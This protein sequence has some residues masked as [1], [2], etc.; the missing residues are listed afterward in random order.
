MTE[1]SRI[2]IITGK[3][4]QNANAEQLSG[5]LK[6]AFAR[7]IHVDI[8]VLQEE[9]QE[10]LLNAIQFS[11]LDGVIF[12]PYSFDSKEYSDNLEQFLSEHC[13]KPVVRIGIEKTSFTQIWY[14]ANKEIAEITR[15]LI[16]V[17]HCRQLLCLTEQEQ[18]PV[19][20]ERLSGFREALAEAGIPCR[21][22]ENIIYGDF[23]LFTVQKL[24][25]EFANGTRTLPEAI[26]CTDDLLAIALCDALRSYQISVPENVLVT[27][28]ENT[29]GTAMHSPSV[30]TYAPA[31]EQLGRRALCRLY[32]LITGKKISPLKREKGSF[33]RR[34]SCGCPEKFSPEMYSF[35]PEQNMMEHSLFTE[36]LSC[37]SLEKFS[38]MMYQLNYLFLQP[39]HYPDE[40]Y[41]LCLH[42]NW[43]Q[44][45]FSHTNHMLRLYEHGGYALFPAE[46][47]L[48]PDF[49][50][51]EQP[52]A[53]FFCPVQFQ[54]NYFGYALLQYTGI[55]EK[56]H[57][58]YL[59][60]CQEISHALEFLR[61]RNE[62]ES[63]AYHDYLSGVR[64]TLTG[65]YHLNQLPEMWQEYLARVNFRKQKAFWLALNISGIDQLE[66]TQGSL[67][68]DKLLV[69]FA[70]LLQNVCSE[71]ENCFRAGDHTFLIL[72]SEPEAAP[73]HTIMVQFIRERFETYQYHR[74]QMLLPVQAAVL[75][76]EEIQ[77]L[78]EDTLITAAS[79]LVARSKANQILYADR[80]HDK[81]LKKLRQQIYQMPEK[82]WSVKLCSQQ[83]NISISYF[84]KIYFKTFG[85]TCAYDIRRSKME[86]G[87]YLLLHTSDT[88]QEI[89][90]KCGY[91]YSHFMRTFRKFY[92]MT[93]TEYRRGK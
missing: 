9:K 7:N 54:E 18:D 91:E 76:D 60:F 15:H 12:L 42:E 93:P 59:P 45:K 38:I 24:A 23:Y 62:L 32:K 92:Q 8:F 47:M 83:L 51:S 13:T 25:Q 29:F 72:G 28:Y 31:W 10:H 34:H 53:T 79:S 22:Q 87:K 75:T 71:Q 40:R 14:S 52:T 46:Q 48:P 64:D 39:D 80:L 78:T 70:E 89:C 58:Y 41:C 84:C 49:Q 65:L 90:R 61:I 33:I 19:S 88:I 20:F 86:H 2:G 30:T 67:A 81:A 85:V 68:K 11:L 44:K 6:E 21:E 82:E 77:L 35:Y 57:P 63:L 17:H 50:D 69:A 27:G 4:S 74:K 56:L 3:I 16:Q 37:N 5:I 26:V 36:L 43:S 73:Y 55:T 1:P 66:E